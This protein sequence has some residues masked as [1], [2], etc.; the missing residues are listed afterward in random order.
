[1]SIPNSLFEIIELHISFEF[2]NSL[3]QTQILY[4]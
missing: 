4:K 1:M 2:I 3:L